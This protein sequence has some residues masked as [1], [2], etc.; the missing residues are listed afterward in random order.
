[1]KK[2]T[3]FKGLVLIVLCVVGVGF[4][5]GW[6]VL[7]SHQDVA[8]SNKVDVNLTVHPDKMKEDA[9]AVGAG[10]KDLSNK[11]TTQTPPSSSQDDVKSN[12]K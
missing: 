9:K 12:D 6:F 2:M 4:Y 7:S 5:R 10:A 3:L 1:M 11:V 8:G